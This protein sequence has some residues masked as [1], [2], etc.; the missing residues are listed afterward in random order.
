MSFNFDDIA[1]N[2]TNDINPRQKEE[3]KEDEEED[4]L[5]QKVKE[6]INLNKS[7]CTSCK[8]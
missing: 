8:G 2:I 6:L 7:G 3:R 4:E 1:A 5:L